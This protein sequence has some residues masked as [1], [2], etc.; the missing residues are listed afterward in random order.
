MDFNRTYIAIRTRGILE[1]LD[2]SMHVV[3]D[4]FVPLL[5][6]WLVGVLP[7]A[8]AN[9]LAIGWMTAD[10]FDIQ[11]LTLY[12]F[13]IAFLIMNQAQVTTLFMTTYLGEAM[14]AQRPSIWTCIKQTL[15]VNPWLVWFQ[16]F[17]RCVIPAFAIVLM[18]GE[19]TRGESFG[20]LYTLFVLLVFFGLI[21]RSI[22]PFGLEILLLE[23]TPVRSRQPG[24]IDYRARS[25]G[26]HGSNS[27]LP[28]RF[29]AM[30]MFAVFLTVSF[31]GSMMLMD[32]WLN[33]HVG[34]ASVP[35]LI[36]LP[37]SMW[38]VAGLLAIVRFLSYID[39]RIR[40]EGWEVELRMR[41]ESMRLEKVLG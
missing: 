24:G 18:I 2:L 23:K 33:L 41:T 15:R 4:H 22:R 34:D 40:Q 20:W 10:Y 5:A 36:Y 16:G 11:Y 12:F 7:F 29:V 1:I 26:L 32:S 35:A 31:F 8:A 19:D 13:T 3:R 37:L 21:V 25:S 28:G 9:W 14:F 39:V 38:M 27:E 6:L 17:Y 30:G